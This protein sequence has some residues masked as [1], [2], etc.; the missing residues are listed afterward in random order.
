M[1]AYVSALDRLRELPAVFSGRDLTVRFAWTA[2]L[3]SSYLAQWRRAKLVRSLGGHSDVH[4]NLV[5]QP[6]ADEQRALR[7]AF[8]RAVVL[9]A[10][11]L[12]GAGWTTQ[13]PHRPDVAVP[14]SGPRYAVEGFN[15]EPRTERWYARVSPGVQQVAGSVARLAPAW[16]LADMIARAQDARVRGAW[17]L[18]PDDIDLDAA[19]AD[20]ALPQA[21]HAFGLPTEAAAE[22]AYLQAYEAVQLRRRKM[23]P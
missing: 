4:M 3:A 16:A 7:M 19:R 8:P 13:V 5:A 17:L 18:A 21:L 9:G 14:V 11:V 23:R 20:A 22:D 2:A 1:A 6:Q 12:R 10:E 15:L